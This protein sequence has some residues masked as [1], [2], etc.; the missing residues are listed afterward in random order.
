MSEDHLKAITLWQPWASAMAAEMKRNETRSW[1]TDYRGPLLI[2]AAARRPTECDLWVLEHPA[3]KLRLALDNIDPKKF[4]LGA[5]V[6]IVKLVDC[7]RVETI[8]DTLSPMELA[9]GN[10]NNGRYAWITEFLHYIDKPIPMKG[11]Q[12]FWNCDMGYF[13]GEDE[14]PIAALDGL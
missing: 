9:L 14:S 6:C 5:A 8:R 11:A 2:H 7:V 12:G 4:P 10:Y 1:R 3:V 13:C